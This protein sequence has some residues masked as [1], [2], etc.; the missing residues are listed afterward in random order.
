MYFRSSCIDVNC[1]SAFFVSVFR[2]QAGKFRVPHPESTSWHPL[3]GRS[4]DI[5]YLEVELYK[6]YKDMKEKL[7]T[8]Y[9]EL[10]IQPQEISADEGDQK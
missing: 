9:K 6:K 5:A 10:Q 1:D 2:R 8:L 7:R 3:H 4:S